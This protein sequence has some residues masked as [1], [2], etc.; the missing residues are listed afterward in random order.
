[1][2]LETIQAGTALSFSYTNPSFLKMG[3]LLKIRTETWT[4]QANN[5]ES[6]DIPGMT[7]NTHFP[8]TFV[9]GT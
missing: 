9:M 8:G 7:V 6:M 2:P 4:T 1:M 3:L 5:C